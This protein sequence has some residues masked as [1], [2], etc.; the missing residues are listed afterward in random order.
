[1][2]R[3][4]RLVVLREIPEDAELRRQWDALVDHVDQPQVFYTYEWAVAVQSAYSQTLH[5]LVILA[6]DDANT[7]SGIAALATE[8]NDHRATFL[9][10]T[11]GDYCDFLSEAENKRAFVRAT[12]EEIAR[13]GIRSLVLTN[14]PADSSTV[15]ALRGTLPG[16]SFHC[17][18]RT[19]YVCAQVSFDGV[20]R[21]KDGTPYAPGLKRLRRFEKAMVETAPVR[22]EHRRSWATVEPLLPEFA[23][24]HVARFLEVGRISNLADPRRRKFLEEL[25]KLLCERQWFVFSR[26]LTGD[27][28][29]AWHYGFVF[30]GSWFWYQPTFDS[31]V[32]KHWPGFCLLSQVIQDAIETP[33]MKM[34]DLGL[35][36]EIYKVKFANQSRETLYITL[37]A[38]WFSHFRTIARYRLTETVRRAPKLERSI[39]LLRGRL[40]RLRSRL[41]SGAGKDLLAWITGRLASLVWARDEVFF[42]DLS[43]PDPSLLKAADIVLNKI[44]FRVLATAVL[45]NSDDEGTLEY[46]V[47]CADRLR[48]E[49]DSVGYALANLKGE[50]LHFT[51]ARPFEGFYWSELGSK[52]PAPAA[53]SVVLF[54]SWTPA[55]HRGRGHYAPTLGRVVA[56]MKEEGRSCWGFSASTNT[57]SVRGLE[58]AGFRRSFSVFRYRV[59]G[60]QKIVR[61]NTILPVFNRA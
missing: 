21:K 35:G 34:L 13:R 29:V 11:T 9:C 28:P 31:V 25:G 58:K 52:L 57:P 12:L 44:D 54:D 55:A 1:M 15:S 61:K 47:R 10:A 42:Y 48:T 30:G 26:M 43:S 23:T 14:L 36:S 18:A 3:T 60:W 45:Q 8:S 27:R 32:D 4:L 22:T 40:H 49:P 53:G 2:I 7:L 20:E 38:S 46:I 24:A 50:L 37:N 41:R 6:Y 33:G 5:P 16:K 39:T 51:W 19:A 59:L 17:F 56:T